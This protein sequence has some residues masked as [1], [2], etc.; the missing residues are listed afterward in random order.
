MQ[1]ELQTI[2]GEVINQRTFDSG[3]AILRVEIDKGNIATLV[4]DMPNFAEGVII[5]ASAHKVEHPKYGLQFRVSEIEEKGF[6]SKE[7]VINYLSTE[8]VKL[9][10]GWLLIISENLLLRC[11]IITLLEFMKFL[12]CLKIKLN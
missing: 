7:A 11:L 5:Q 2:K 10:Q 8:L 3:Y 6:A 4:G 9:W 12:D 1:P